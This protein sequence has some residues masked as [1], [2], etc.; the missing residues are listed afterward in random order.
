[1]SRYRGQVADESMTL[2]HAT[3]TC[4]HTTCFFR[5]KQPRT[6]SRRTAMMPD[7]SAAGRPRGARSSKA[8]LRQQA[9]MQQGRRSQRGTCHTKS[10]NKSFSSRHRQAGVRREHCGS[11]PQDL[12]K[13][14]QA[15]PRVFRKQAPTTQAK[16]ETSTKTSRSHATR[17]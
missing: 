11:A 1:M 14:S 6:H 13:R 10:H 12:F 2:A 16:C 4:L 15:F 3:A 8:R 7:S 5:W 17:G 9:A